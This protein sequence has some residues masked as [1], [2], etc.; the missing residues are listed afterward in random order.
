MPRSA[1]RASSMADRTASSGTSIGTL[2]T[3]SS[4]ERRSGRAA[5]QLD[6]ADRAISSRAPPG[7]WA[8]L[9]R[10]NRVS[11]STSRA[12]SSSTGRPSSSSGSISAASAPWMATA[13]TRSAQICPRRLLPQPAGPQIAITPPIR[14]GQSA[15]ASTADRLQSDTTKPSAPSG[16]SRCSGNR[17]WS[18]GVGR[19]VIGLLLAET[20]RQGLHARG[21]AHAS[22][23]ARALFPP[24]IFRSFPTPDP[25]FPPHDPVRTRPKSRLRPFLTQGSASLGPSE[26]R[27][28]GEC[29]DKAAFRDFRTGRVF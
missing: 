8:R 6:G 4:R 3:A 20:G 9:I 25:A 16:R 15:R 26:A 17:I 12:G 2:M 7:A 22:V 5:S 14:L 29:I 1:N 13:P 19:A 18:A 23:D 21:Q 24:P 11:S 10:W 28:G 27:E